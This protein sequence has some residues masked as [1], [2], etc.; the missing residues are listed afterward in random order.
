MEQD[1]HSCYR[2]G[3]ISLGKPVA[4]YGESSHNK[5]VLKQWCADYAT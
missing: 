4:K 3:C 2:K 1:G 5:Q